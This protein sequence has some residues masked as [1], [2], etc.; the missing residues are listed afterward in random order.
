MPDIRNLEDLAEY[1]HQQVARIQRMQDD[2]ADQYGTGESPRGY[3][4]ARTGPGGAIQELRID[5]G[6][7]RLSAE[8]VA[9]EVTAA[10][11]EAQREYNGRANEIIAPVLAAAPS[12]D[13]LGRLDEGMRR[14]DGLMDD[15][16]R[17]AR[18]RDL[19]R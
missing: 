15:L 17:V 6:A 1:A 2:L 5:P 11:G 10:I 7:L 14:L 4:R 16:D 13:S 19:D 8:D 18:R 3:V 12:E 9:A